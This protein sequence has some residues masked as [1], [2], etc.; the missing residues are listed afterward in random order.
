MFTLSI[1]CLIIPNLPWFM[2]LPFQ[3]PMQYCSLQHWTLLSPPDTPTA[4]HCFH[5]SS[6]FSFFLELPLQSSK[7][8]YWIPTYLG[9]HLSVSYLFPFSYCSWGSQGKN[10]EVV[11]HSL[12]QGTMFCQNSLPWYVCLGWPY[13]AW[14]MVSL[15]KARLWSVWL[16][17]C[18]CDFHFVSPLMDED[19]RLVEAS[20]WE[21]L[22][23]GKTRS[24]SGG[25]GHTQSVQFSCL[26]TSDSLW[27]HGL[28][29]A[30]PPH[31]S[32]TPRAYSNLYPWS[33][34]CHPAFNF[35]QHQGIFKWVSSSHQVVK[36]LTFQLQHQSFH[37]I[38]SIAFL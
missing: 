21:G 1:S 25:Q 3:V 19:K 22:A 23:V 16:V 27:P 37:W 14:L 11:C 9:V 7:V 18:D 15:S 31:P 33:R 32:P 8:A 34:W 26:V 17:F 30:R 6:V 2:D 29:H 28:Q 13:T 36:V 12:L 38:F 5:F 24:C 20:W 35:Y 10:T 4:R